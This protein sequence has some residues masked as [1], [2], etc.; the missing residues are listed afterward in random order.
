MGTKRPHHDDPMPSESASVRRTP[1][2][3]HGCIELVNKVASGGFDSFLLAIISLLFGI[4]INT[5]GTFSSA[6]TVRQDLI[7]NLSA[8]GQNFGVNSKIGLYL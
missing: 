4:L 5:V 8:S 3:L 7:P 1:L 6:T 2:L